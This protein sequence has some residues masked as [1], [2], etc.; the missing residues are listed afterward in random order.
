M[1]LQADSRVQGNTESLQD[2]GV[3]ATEREPQGQL[4]DHL[5]DQMAAPSKE[6]GAVLS[7]P[8]P[9][10]WAEPLK[11]LDQM[12][13]H[14]GA[15]AAQPGRKAWAASSR[16]DSVAPPVMAMPIPA[17]LKV[18]TMLKQDRA[19]TTAANHIQM[20]KQGSNMVI[21]RIHSS[22]KGRAAKPR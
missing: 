1:E 15:A 19:P 4:E 21:T 5:Q 20:P 6:Q 22:R 11:E 10:P 3:F 16:P 17:T 18:P 7:L 13:A 12:V 14:I 2:L 9:E 8:M